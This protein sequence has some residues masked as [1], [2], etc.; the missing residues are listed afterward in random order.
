M[1]LS[2]YYWRSCLGGACLQ[3]P[4]TWEIKKKSITSSHKFEASLSNIA[5]PSLNKNKTKALLRGKIHPQ[6]ESLKLNSQW[7][8]H[9]VTSSHSFDAY[10]LIV[11]SLIILAA[12][13]INNQ[14]FQGTSAHPSIKAQISQMKKFRAKQCHIPNRSTRHLQNTWSSCSRIHIPFIS[15][16]KHFPR[17]IF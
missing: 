16:W 14:C 7:I 1:V 9:T 3:F 6:E 4:A 13:D 2:K 5:R 11:Q 12:I 8:Y 10:S 17:Q 15:G